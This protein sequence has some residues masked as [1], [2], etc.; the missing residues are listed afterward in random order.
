MS[1]SLDMNAAPSSSPPAN[2]FL[3]AMADIRPSKTDLGPIICPGHSRPVPDIAFTDFTPDGYFLIS[4]CLDNKAMLRDGVTG[5]WIGTFIG[6]KGAVWCA[7]LNVPATRAVTGAAD[8]TAKLWDAL[9]GDELHSFTHKHIVKSCTFD[10]Q[11]TQIYTGGNEQKVRVWDLEK[12]DEAILTLSGH[13]AGVTHVIALADDNLIVSAAAEP[14]VKIW[15]KRTGSVVRTITT[16]GAVKGAQLSIDGTTLSL[17]T[18]NKQVAFYEMLPNLS[19]APL[20]TYTMKEPVDCLSFSPASSSVTP[21]F[22]CGSM[23]ELWARLYR[24]DTGEEIAVNKGHHGPVR[25]LCFSPDSTQ[26][27]SG[28]ED[29]TI[30]IWS[31]PLAKQSQD[32]QS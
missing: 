14:D 17:C 15:D 5:D 9:T 27:A 4:A 29:G 28:S 26:Y 13:T 3:A 11:S 8:F 30:R 18:A 10:H 24:F 25:S 32:N 31:N 2:S 1:D 23:S 6:H 20:K 16:D 12:P 7:R 19:D 22:V 21:S